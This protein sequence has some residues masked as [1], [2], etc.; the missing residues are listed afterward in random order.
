M[1]STKIVLALGAA[2][3]MLS[4]SACGGGGG[5]PLAT[6]GSSGAPS[7]SGGTSASG[8]SSASGGV[9][10]IVVGS[11]DF[12]ES[13][14]IAAIYAGALK[15]K[16]VTVEEKPNIG[17]REIYLGALKDGSID[18]VPEYT[19]ALALYY[20]KTVPIDDP[21][22]VYAKL[23]K[24]VPDSLA[25]LAKSAAEDKDAIVVTKAT[26]DKYHLKAIPDLVG[27]AKNMTL[28]APPEF[29]T[30]TQG[31]PGLKKTYNVDFGSFRP[32]K[33]AALSN[34]LKNGQVDAANIFTTDPSIAVNGFVALDDTKGLFGA[35]NVVPLISKDK[36]NG[37]VKS[38]LNAVSAKLTTDSL[39]A[40]NKQVQVE[41]KDV[42]AVAKSFLSTNSLG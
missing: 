8:G 35:Q 27:P 15:A 25:V 18:L 17:A 40:M 34:A 39:L 28:G 36:L 29:K 16:G 12:A 30:R 38:A 21:D 11:A 2:T 24:L 4:I 32:L 20:D 31:V 41:H 5:S 42:A 6:G 13:Q 10:T 23:Q 33:G 14:L 22:K 9:G 3:A 1:K 19:G 37:T 7:G 26:A